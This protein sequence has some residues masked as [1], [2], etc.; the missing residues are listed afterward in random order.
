MLWEVGRIVGT[1]NVRS[2]LRG[3]T[4]AIARLLITK[5]VLSDFYIACFFSVAQTTAVSDDQGL[6]AE[7]EVEQNCRN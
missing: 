2:A 6:A 3:R 4:A 7:I 1:M 5:C